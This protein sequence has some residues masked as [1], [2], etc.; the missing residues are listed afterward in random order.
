[1]RV[2]NLYT[3]NIFTAIF[4]IEMFMKI[5]AYGFVLD[6]YTYL[7]DP[8][9]WL[10]FIIVVTG[11]ISY[12]PQV[13][14]NLLA[15]RTFRL[16]RPLKTIS[17]L[18]NMR[19]FIATLINSLLDLSSVFMML[20]FFFFL[21]AILGLSIWTDRLSFMCR[22]NTQPYQG[23]FNPDPNYSTSLCGGR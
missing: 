20:L 11:L 4:T 22:T 5:I 9:N 2:V 1:M 15:L 17:M 6:E 7:R 18:P 10:D 23:Y 14:A 16:I 8:W 13:D 12:L 3:N 19:I 21:F